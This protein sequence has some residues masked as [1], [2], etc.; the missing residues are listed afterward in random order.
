MKRTVRLRESE[1]RRMISESVK[2][3]LME[4]RFKG[5][6]GKYKPFADSEE[7]EDDVYLGKDEGYPYREYVTKDG[8]LHTHY[9]PMVQHGFSREWGSDNEPIDYDGRYDDD[10]TFHKFMGTYDDARSKMINQII[11]DMGN[12]AALNDKVKRGLLNAFSTLSDDELYTLYDSDL[13]GGN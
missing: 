11:D 12:R 2:R 7:T 8:K 3:V 5:K 6:I 4:E 10:L 9:T 13:G 1:L